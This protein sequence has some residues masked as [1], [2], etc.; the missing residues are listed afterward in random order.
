MQTLGRRYVGRFNFLRSRTGTLWEGRYKATIVDTD[1]YLLT[2][3]RYIELNPVRA[4]MVTSPAEYRWS[5]YRANAC[6][7]HDPVVTPHPMFVALA[8]TPDER[9]DIY[10]RMFGE[11]LPNEAIEAIRNATQFEWALG[12]T[13]FHE[14]V[15][16]RTGRRTSRLAMGRPRADS[17]EESRL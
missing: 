10:R 3:L 12:D 8:P 1:A 14:F 5:S 11:A 4:H 17:E 2:C 9:R 13:A 6:G 16:A 7:D 15:E